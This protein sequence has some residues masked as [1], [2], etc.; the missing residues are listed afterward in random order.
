MCG[1]WDLRVNCIISPMVHIKLELWPLLM[2]SN[3][4]FALMDLCPVQQVKN[5][6]NSLSKIHVKVTS[7]VKDSF[8]FCLTVQNAGFFLV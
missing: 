7:N 1:S 8:S 5:N 6:V 3:P 4:A 2:I